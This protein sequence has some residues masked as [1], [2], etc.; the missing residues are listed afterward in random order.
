M[1]PGDEGPKFT[2]AALTLRRRWRFDGRGHSPSPLRNKKVQKTFRKDCN[3]SRNWRKRHAEALP[4][5]FW[6]RSPISWRCSE[7]P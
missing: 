6:T 2:L 3:L 5:P 1:S 7:S 4:Y